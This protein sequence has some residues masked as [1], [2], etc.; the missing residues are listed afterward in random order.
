M[1]RDEMIGG[2]VVLVFGA[3]TTLLS[4]R[5]P[6]G[7]FRKSGTGFFPLILGMLLMVLS[8]IFLL[9]LSL[10]K[11]RVEK[12]VPIP[13]I[14]GSTKQMILFF[15]MMVLATLFLN[16]LGYPVVSFLLMVGL[17]RILGTKRWS[18]NLLLSLLTALACYFLFVQWLKIP[19]PKGWI[20]I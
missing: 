9:Q 7:T 1:K 10:D 18:F 15:G 12:K 5:M 19:L 17:L 20:G 8:G 14:S 2:V 16:R 13:E 3:I 11:K 4:L 6:I